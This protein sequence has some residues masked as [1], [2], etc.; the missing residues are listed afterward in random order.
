MP[1]CGDDQPRQYGR[2]DLGEQRHRQQCHNDQKTAAQQR[3]HARMSRGVA[4]GRH[5]FFHAARGGQGAEH[6]P[7]DIGE[8]NGIEIAASATPL[9]GFALQGRGAGDGFQNPEDGHGYRSGHQY[10]G[11]GTEWER[12][13]QG[14]KRR[15]P[16]GAGQ[17]G[18]HKRANP[19]MAP[20]KQRQ[21]VMGHDARDECHDDGWYGA[22][23]GHPPE[24]CKHRHGGHRQRAPMRAAMPVGRHS[25][26]CVHL[27]Q[28][29]QHRGTVPQSRQHGVGHQWRD[30]ANTQR[31]NPRGQQAA[32]QREGHRQPHSLAGTG[33]G[34]QSPLYERFQGR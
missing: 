33:G 16:C 5:R 14:V 8:R 18:C 19:F 32:T 22:Q 20:R 9:P 2:R 28:D 30:T 3:C 1:R 31:G 12:R 24:R 11:H 23:A 27:L 26:H 10:L 15:E 21:R 7:G 4:R 29:E 25:D 34:Q 17:H 13:K 6:A